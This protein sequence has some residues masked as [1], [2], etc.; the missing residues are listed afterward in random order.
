MKMQLKVTPGFLKIGLQKKKNQSLSEGLTEI[1]KI[2]KKKKRKAN[3]SF[4]TG[5]QTVIEDGKL[6][7]MA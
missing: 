2:K 5:M 3:E 1:M 6:K 7:A 4:L